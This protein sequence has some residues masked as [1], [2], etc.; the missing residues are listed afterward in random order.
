[1]FLKSTDIIYQFIRLDMTIVWQFYC[2]RWVLFVFA[3]DFAWRDLLSADEAVDRQQE[4]SERREG[5]GTDVARYRPL[6]LLSGTHEGGCKVS[7]VTC[8]FLMLL[9][10]WV[11]LSKILWKWVQIKKISHWITQTNVH[12]RILY[13]IINSATMMLLYKQNDIKYF[14]F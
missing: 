13:Q 3:G 6:H 2:W 1:M 14:D 9:N 4:Q 10:D 11:L 8:L 7:L 5:L 12:S